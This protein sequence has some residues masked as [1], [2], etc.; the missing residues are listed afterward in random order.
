MACGAK[1]LGLLCGGLL[2]F[3]HIGIGLAVIEAL[4][5]VAAPL[6]EHC[7]L[8]FGLDALGGDGHVQRLAEATMLDTMAEVCGLVP[9]VSMN[10]RSILI[11]LT[12]KRVR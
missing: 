6:P 5:L 1:R 8:A 11:F 9:S 2:G 3:R 7:R 4:H 12:G 10:E